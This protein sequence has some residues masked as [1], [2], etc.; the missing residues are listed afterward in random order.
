MID[1]RAERYTPDRLIRSERRARQLTNLL[2]GAAMAFVALLCFGSLFALVGRAG[3]EITLNAAD[4]AAVRFTLLQAVLSASISCALAVPVARALSRRRFQGRETLITLLGAPFVLPGIVAV[5]GIIAIWGRSGLVSDVCEIVGLERLNVYGLGGVVLGHVFFNLPLATRI[6]LQGWAAIPSEHW[7][8]A[9]QLGMSPGAVFRRLERPVLRET[10]PGAFLL[11]FL[12]CMTS[13]V[14]ALTLGG[15][16]GS[17]TIE[18]AIFQ[19]LRFDFEL[20]RAAL[21][22]VIQFLLCLSVGFTVLRLTRNSAF[23]RG[24]DQPANLWCGTSGLLRAQDV[25]AISGAVL[26]LCVPLIAV[27]LRGIGALVSGLPIEVFEAALTSLAIALPSGA[28]ALSMGLPMA[29]QLARH[30]NDRR[31]AL[32]QIA[33]VMI[34]AASPFV[35]GT[36][37]FILVN[38]FADPFLLALPVTMLVN[39]LM[40]LPFVIRIV[41]PG[42]IRTRADYG[43]L[44]SS[45]GLVGWPLFR[46]AIWP[47]LRPAVGFAAGLATA[48]SI[49]DLGVVTLF[50]PPDVAT[51]PLAIYRLMGA[52]RMADAAGASLL[53]FGLTLFVFWIFDQGGRIGHRV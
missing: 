3:N 44:S 46:L 12:L 21:L 8:L 52:Y 5:L 34:L 35:V 2:G 43:G 23:G 18:L 6:L 40:S 39:A 19:A 1:H 33:G 4:W 28:L 36:G 7:R 37:L 41:L 27:F 14:V 11:I 22:A 25:L 32:S 13:F 53:L 29:A 15:G 17:S 31:G 16:P 48:L 49:G 24:L 30:G 47:R 42:M 50:A 9:A 38:P 26:F 10:L 45:L 20:G 51:L